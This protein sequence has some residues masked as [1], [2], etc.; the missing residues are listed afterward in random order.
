MFWIKG[1]PGCGKST[2]MKYIFED[3]R[4]RIHLHTDQIRRSDAVCLAGFFFYARGTSVQKS[5]IGLLRSILIQIL[6]CFPSLM[7]IASPKHWV[8]VSNQSSLREDL[9]TWS[10]GDLRQALKRLLG[11]TDVSGNICLFIDGLDEYEG[12]HEDLVVFLEDLISSSYG[13]RLKLKACI[14]SRPLLIFEHHFNTHQGLCMHDLTAGDIRAYVTSALET[15]EGLK[16][17]QKTHK[18]EVRKLVDDLVN[19]ANGIFL[20][21]R[22]AVKSMRQGLQDGDRVSELQVRIT[23]IPPDLY[24]FYK[25]ILCGIKSRQYRLQAWEML[26]IVLVHPDIN[27]LEFAFA[28]EGP[29]E[30]ISR[31]VKPLTA[32]EKTSLGRV[33]EKR[34]NSRCAGLVEVV[35]DTLDEFDETPLAEFYDLES[36]IPN[37]VEEPWEEPFLRSRLQLSHLTVAEFLKVSDVSDVLDPSPKTSFD[38]CIAMMSSYLSLL[39]IHPIAWAQRD[40]DDGYLSECNSDTWISKIISNAVAALP[41]SSNVIAA[42]LDEMDFTMTERSADKSVPWF[43]CRPVRADVS[44]MR[45]YVHCMDEHEYCD[46]MAWP[47]YWH[48][49]FLAFTAF[50]RLTIYVR[51]CIGRDEMLL[52]RKKAGRPLLFYAIDNWLA[53]DHSGQQQGLPCK[54]MV[55]LVLLN[56][57]QIDDCFDN[58]SPWELAIARAT[59]DGEGDSASTRSN[60]WL[61]IFHLL[62]DHGA[63]PNVEVRGY[64]PLK[65][66]CLRDIVGHS[67]LVLTKLYRNNSCSG[68]KQMLDRVRERSTIDLNTQAA[69]NLVE[70]DP[71]PKRSR[72]VVT[73]GNACKVPELIRSLGVAAVTMLV[74]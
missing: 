31:D 55:E 4:T 13:Q 46:R 40:S 42:I 35:E 73:D 22:L 57:G 60:T 14:A 26:H 45:D 61:A 12:D 62:L 11:Q 74:T 47:E 5:L 37:F 44:E 72:Y 54:D 8:T 64:D 65:P 21:M 53:E 67:L 41:H 20:W 33:A 32:S 9:P 49:D 15:S 50:S 23:E 29:Q 52:R 51:V 66:W 38:P 34:L 63:D 59:Y 39:K 28:D 6:E 19:K 3:N 36:G 1:K 16:H 70:P 2:L 24:D 7:S 18:A 58:R 56:G 10:P 68:V 69:I 30:A 25:A 48:A 17:L 43:T 27:L 71:P